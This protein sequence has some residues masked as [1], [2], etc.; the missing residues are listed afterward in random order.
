MEKI[1]YETK[2]EYK[3][4]LITVT[5]QSACATIWFNG[6]IFK[7]IAG[8][9]FADGRHNAVEKAKTYIDTHA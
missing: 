3:G 7:M 9:I 1:V 4:Y 6:E 2:T 8:D 5:P